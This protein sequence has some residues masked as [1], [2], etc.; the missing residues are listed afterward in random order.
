VEGEGKRLKYR[1]RWYGEMLNEKPLADLEIKRKTNFLS[2][3]LRS[4]VSTFESA[5]GIDARS[6]LG[7]L[8]RVSQIELRPNLELLQCVLVNRYRRRYFRTAD[9]R[10][11]ITLGTDLKYF[12]LI[13]G[14]TNLEKSIQ[15]SAAIIEVKYTFKDDPVAQGL[16]NLI[17]HRVTKISK[18]VCD[19]EILNMRGFGKFG[20]FR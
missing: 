3:K 9:H 18:Y 2:D 20:F 17:P 12:P 1:I 6:T 4:K 16:L 8:S 10:F 19:L 14:R 5:E 15:N 11:R 7:A 13:F